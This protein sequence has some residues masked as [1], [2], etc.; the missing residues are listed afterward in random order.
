VA[1]ASDPSR[2]RRIALWA[3]MILLLFSMVE[4]GSA[5]FLHYVTTTLAHF[6]VWDPDVEAAREAWEAAPG[7]WDN[8]I[9]WP[10]PR[11][12]VSLPRD[13]SGAK[14]NAE[15]PQAARACI[16]AYGDSFVWG[17]EIPME[18]GWPE[19]LSHKLGCRVSN[20]GV[21][22]YGTDQAYIRF[23]RNAWDEAPIVLLGIFPEDV[24]RNVNQYRGFTGYPVNP[25]W[26][27]GRYVLHR[28]GGLQWLHRPRIDEAGYLRLIGEPASVIPNDF[29]LPDT[30]DGP[31]T[32]RFPYTLALTRLL[33]KPR[34]WARLTG[35]PTWTNFYRPDHPSGALSLTVAIVEAFARTA[36]QRGE[37]V[38]VV[39]LPGESSFRARAK[40]GEPEYLPLLTAL[41]A[42]H[43][44][45]FDTGPALLTALGPRSSCDLYVHP[46][47]DGHYGVFGSGVV[48]DVVMQELRRRG[49]VK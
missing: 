13:S 37:S 20:Y 41:A 15:F 9:G 46:A 36:E 2:A 10:S 1:A 23:E 16:S 39:M 40:F 26:L 30:R 6:L 14:M 33:L 35:R 44:E 29:L 22:G 32:L 7:N 27:K 48:A 17:D 45:V 8:E 5:I 3:I 18:D 28:D 11:D 21:S 25:S 24:M 31:V 42:R 12:S 19:Q 43:I 49:L 47:C 38:L 4:G 34:V